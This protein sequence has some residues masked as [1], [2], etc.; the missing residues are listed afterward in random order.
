MEFKIGDWIRIK[1]D[2]QS[3]DYIA[4]NDDGYSTKS[5]QIR[6]IDHSHFPF[7]KNYGVG[8]QIKLNTGSSTNH[9][10]WVSGENVIKSCKPKPDI[11]K[12]IDLDKLSV[13]AINT[14]VWV[15]M[16][17]RVQK[18][19]IVNYYIGEVGL[20]VE[21]ADENWKQVVD[22]DALNKVWFS[23]ESLAWEKFGENKRKQP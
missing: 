20:N 1:V 13:P 22:W 23:D 2:G 6:N 5:F 21:L 15:V 4:K 10:L 7:N 17:D 14:S 11:I 9:Y 3:T 8:Y 16:K 12:T 18:A 19:K